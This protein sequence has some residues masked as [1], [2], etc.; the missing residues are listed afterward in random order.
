MLRA[1]VLYYVVLISFII[2]LISGLFLLLINLFNTDINNQIIKS[3]VVKN[4]SSGYNIILND[5][6]LIKEKNINLNII[7]NEKY[8][9]EFEVHSWGA[10]K[11]IKGKSN[12]YNYSIEKIALTGFNT[13]SS[14]PVALYLADENKY[15]SVSG[16][17]SINGICYLPKLGIRRASIEGKIYTGDNL[18][19]GEIKTSQASLPSIDN[20]LVEINS[21]YFNNSFSDNDSLI[22]FEDIR[23]T[24]SHSFS[25]KC[26]AYYSDEPILINQ[27][28]Y[29]NIKIISD[30]LIYV[31][32]RA[33]LDGIIIYA[34]IIIFEALFKGKLQAFARDTII[35]EDNCK[36][37]FPS[38][39]GLL[40]TTSSDSIVNIGKK[41]IKIGQDCSLSGGIF[42]NSNKSLLRNKP[43]LYMDRYSKVNGLV[44]C[45]GET[46]LKGEING[47][48]YC[49][50]FTL[51]T[52]AAY[53]EN[54][55]LDISVDYYALSEFF[56]SPYILDQYPKSR[57]ISWL[58]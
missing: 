57:I 19:D 1:G 22:D 12:Y 43:I 21:I 53:Y 39:L 27:K 26:I 14:E 38:F 45:D 31:D 46:E 56:V 6:S 51:R 2:S 47:S 11:I 49:R 23:N 28:L 41:M 18:V 4:L 5:E 42:I 52:R 34:P 20:S 37:Q 17:S 10:F 40:N 48:L 29:G 7:E 58:N 8:N 24:V 16:N 3:Q 13:F 32:K 50:N 9:T 54:H 55:L 25:K 36:F 15:L 35:A 33:K 44:Y 30:S